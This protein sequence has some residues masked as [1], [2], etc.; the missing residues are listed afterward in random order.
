MHIVQQL[1]VNSTNENFHSKMGHS[2]TSLQLQG[3]CSAFS[4]QFPTQISKI[5]Q[6]ENSLANLQRARVLDVLML[7][8]YGPMW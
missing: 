4:P 8:S 2:M 3:A 1:E 7:G 5:N 6:I